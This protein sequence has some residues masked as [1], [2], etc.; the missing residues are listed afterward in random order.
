MM[1]LV[2]VVN[3]WWFVVIGDG[4]VSDWWFVMFVH[5]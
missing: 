4:V 2:G 5:V 1:W 3:D